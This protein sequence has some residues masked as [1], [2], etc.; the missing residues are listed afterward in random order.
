MK[1][2]TLHIP[3]DM[4]EGRLFPWVKRMLPELPEY[5]VKDAFSKRD[6]KLNGQRVDQRA[7]LVPGAELTLYTRDIAVREPVKILYQDDDLLIVR[8]PAGISCEADA[9]G[10]KT[11]TEL[12][13]DMVRKENP[14]EKEPLLCHRLDNPTD[15]L[16]LLARNPAAQQDMEEA[17]RNRRVHKR[18]VCIVKGTPKPEHQ[19]LKAY[20]VKDAEKAKVRI[21]SHSSPGA[22][23]VLT[24]Y[25]VL[26]SGSC[27]RLDI[28]LHTG[29]TH[30]IR[31][32]MAAIGHPLLGDDLYGDRAFNK[33]MKAKQLM[34]CAASLSFDM[35]G[36]WGYLNEQNITIDPEF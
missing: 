17:F 33:Q 8:K 5:A 26:E 21:V 1:R 10:G 27:S 2:Y 4:T 16:L 13:W 35:E 31:A 6:V 12:V 30:Q 15:G 36:K 3:E 32:Q 29:R 7:M 24:E 20:L 19:L 11:V 9:K 14:L 28:A 18:Y 22:L 25:T 34:L 23:G